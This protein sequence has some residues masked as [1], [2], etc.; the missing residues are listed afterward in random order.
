MPR[1]THASR[2][3]PWPDGLRRRATDLDPWIRGA[4]INHDGDLKLSY[5]AGWG[6]NSQIADE[7]YKDMIQYRHDPTNMMVGS[8]TVIDDVIK[9]IHAGPIE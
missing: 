1:E 5:L 6:I 9:A 2:L 7:L 4:V 8:Q 3:D